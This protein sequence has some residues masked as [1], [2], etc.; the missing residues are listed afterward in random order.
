MKKILLVIIAVISPFFFTGCVRTYLPMHLFTLS[1]PPMIFETNGS[2]STTSKYIGAELTIADGFNKDESIYIARGFYSIAAT[3]DHTNSNIEVF[4]SAGNYKVFGVS[5]ELDGNKSEFSIGGNIKFALNFKLQN[6]KL[7]MGLN[8]GYLKEFGN[9]TNFRKKLYGN[10]LESR[11]SS[12][13]NHTISAFPFIAVQIKKS[14]ILSFQV[15]VG[16]PEIMTP[17]IMYSTSTLS[18]WISYR[19]LSDEE[20]L[21]LPN[22]LAI[23][24]RYKL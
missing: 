7:G 24:V 5:S 14:S 4:A 12:L 10:N 20:I 23:G 15:N 22:K 6:T 3:T 2:D 16:F 17:S 8:Y 18:T 19:G 1:H 21:F 9:Y 11:H 13:H